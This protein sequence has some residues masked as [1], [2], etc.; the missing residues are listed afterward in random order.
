MIKSN[1]ELR[2]LVSLTLFGCF[3]SQVLAGLPLNLHVPSPDWRDQVIYFVVSDRFAD[4]DAAN[5]DQGRGEF[6]AGD[7]SRYNGGDF[8]GLV[9]RLPYIRG[10]GATALWVTP[11]V[12]NQWLD[13][14]G[15]YGGYH[16]YWAENLLQVDRHLGSLADYQ[17]LS[18]ALHERGMYLVQDIVVN[19][20][21]NFFGYQGWRAGQPGLGW[22]GFVGTPPVARPSQAPFDLNDPR[23][24]AQ[25]RAAIYHWTPDVVDYT[26]RAQELNFQMSGLDD[27]NTENLVVR[28]A[29]RRSYGHWIREVGV[30]AFRIDTAFYVPAGF[31]SD[32]LHSTERA[33]PGIAR[34]AAATGRRGFHVFGE[35]FAIDRPGRDEQSRKIESYMHGPR[36]RPLL[37]GMLNFPLYG[38]LGDVFARGRPAADLGQ[39]ITRM[40]ALHPRLHWM[41]SFVDNHDVD[42]FLAGGGEAGLKQALL[43]LMTLPGIPVIY[44]GTEQ[45][46]VGQRAAMFAAGAG[47]GGRDRFD[48]D[49]PLYKLTAEVI[50]LRRAHKVFS[51]GVP[52]VL[53]G[54]TAQPGAVAW[55][56]VHGRDRAIVVFNSGDS[57]TLLPGLATGLPAGTRLQALY[58]LH[59]RP[60]DLLVGSG[61]KLTLR[62]APRSGLVFKALPGLVPR[63]AP[64]AAITMQAPPPQ[65]SADFTV[66]GSARGVDELLLVVD[67]DIASARRVRP[68]AD[69]GWQAKVDTAGMADA[70]LRHSVVAW[71][72]GQA[73]SASHAFRVRRPWRLLVDQ[74]DPVGDDHGPEGRYSYPSQGSWRSARQMDLQRVRVSDAGG[75]LRLEL[76]LHSVSTRWNPPNGF[77]HVAFTIFIQLPGRDGGASVM[78]LQNGSLPD[79]MRWHLRLR[80]H[81]WSNALFSAAGASADHEGTPVM[82]GAAITTDVK[83]GTV[84]FTLPAAAL[85]RLQSLSGARIYVSTW[86]YDGGYRAIAAEA[87]PYALGG[88]G[89]GAPKVMDDSLVVL[90]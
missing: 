82:P 81:G 25:R 8:K 62:L 38:A 78:P 89:A 60:G 33:A 84:S 53:A 41:P 43:A 32:F 58:G 46:F 64:T 1:T 37:P 14:A 49:A 69:G 40:T 51:R 90:P 6:K 42:R 17:Q 45:G 3:A 73:T 5:N 59:G 30:D 77:D 27:L 23:Q 61:G 86:D 19:H 7:N 68:D 44:Y 26:Q 36:G 22:Q 24:P 12:A 70:G 16:G 47:S 55:K 52:R 21:G 11:P 54:N 48:T 72:D 74:A 79:G 88:G 75:A 34:V 10:L 65:A 13:A 57:E 83:A 67:G 9:D 29:L 4:G 50:A 20:M 56:M 71:A 15:Q 63:P 85:G 31:F 76:K 80:A 35:G 66:R 28:R 2:S 18:H 39:R 87:Q